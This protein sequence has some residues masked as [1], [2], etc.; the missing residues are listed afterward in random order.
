[1]AYKKYT[2]GELIKELEKY[3]KDAKF[4]VHD[5]NEWTLC[6]EIN[7]IHFNE[8]ENILTLEMG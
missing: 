4:Y 6:E 2:V 5:N 3:P 7:V 8:E 1:M